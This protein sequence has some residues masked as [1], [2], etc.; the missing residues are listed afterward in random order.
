M[1]IAA[2]LLVSVLEVAQ[3]ASDA[4]DRGADRPRHGL[5]RPRAASSPRSRTSATT[6]ASGCSASRQSLRAAGDVVRPGDGR[7]RRRRRR[8]PGRDRG[9]GR[10]GRAHLRP[11]ARRHR[12]ADRGLR[13]DAPVVRPG[14][15]EARK[16]TTPSLRPLLH[17]LHR[18]DRH[19]VQGQRPGGAGDR[20]P[21][22]AAGRR[23]D[24]PG[25][26]RDR[27]RGAAHPGPPAGRRASDQLD[28]PGEIAE[29]AGLLGQRQRHL[30]R[31]RATWAPAATARPRPPPSR[32]STRR[33]TSASSSSPSPRTRC[34]SAR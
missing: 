10:R 17:G 8:V 5:D 23:A 29:A 1:P 19:V 21:H 27:E 6:A 18:T 31:H 34:R 15:P 7:D 14:D 12:R 4:D 11:R 33:A 13:A 16:H 22:A 20:R 2:L 28:E 26:A 25:H 30:R 9:E 3:S 32:R 24:R